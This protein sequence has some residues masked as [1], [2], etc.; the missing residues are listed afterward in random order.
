MSVGDT[1]WKWE[2]ELKIS[3]PTVGELHKWVPHRPRRKIPRSVSASLVLRRFISLCLSKVV[4]SFHTLFFYSRGQW[5]KGVANKLLTKRTN[6]QCFVCSSLFLTARLQR[7]S[8]WNLRGYATLIDYLVPWRNKVLLGAMAQKT[9]VE[10]R[11]GTRV[12]LVS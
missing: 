12:Y 6:R 2:D 7:G 4:V 9:S 3:A 11:D 1:P 5:M 10:N 8:D